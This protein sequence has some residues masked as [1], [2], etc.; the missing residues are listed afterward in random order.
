[1]PGTCLQITS[2]QAAE[3]EV[4]ARAEICA[5]LLGQ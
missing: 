4:A 3:T 5:A 1:M 2:A